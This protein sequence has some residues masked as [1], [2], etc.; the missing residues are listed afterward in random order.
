MNYCSVTKSILYISVA[1]STCSCFS[2]SHISAPCNNIFRATLSNS[3]I[4]RSLYVLLNY[5]FRPGS[6]NVTGKFCIFFTNVNFWS[7]WY[8][9]RPKRTVLACHS[10]QLP[11]ITRC[12]S[13]HLFGCGKNVNVSVERKI[14]VKYCLNA[15]HLC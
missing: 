13:N 3:I 2:H 6:A 5:F 10:Q 8:K 11:S 9:H 14:L 1:C 4:L 12:V 15:Y 7:K